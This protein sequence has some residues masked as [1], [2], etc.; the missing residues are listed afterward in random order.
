MLRNPFGSEAM[1]GSTHIPGVAQGRVVKPHR[2][3]PG[4]GLRDPQ[5]LGTAD[6]PLRGFVPR[7]QRL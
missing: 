5:G 6:A 4:R 3:M 1:L 7:R 2:A